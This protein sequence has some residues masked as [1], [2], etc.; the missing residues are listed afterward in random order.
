MSV[1]T[2]AAPAG[3]RDDVPV[4]RLY[5]LGDDQ[6]RRM[7]DAGILDDRSGE[8]SPRLSVA[9]YHEA[10]RLGILTPDDR[11]ELLEGWLVAKM[12]KKP[13]HTIAKGL[14]LDELIRVTPAGWYVVIEDPVSTAESEPEP[15]AMIVRGRRRD[16]RDRQPGP[17]DVAL[18]VEVADSTLADDRRTK[19]RIY[20]RA[21]VAIYWIVNLVDGRVEVYTEPT[22]PDDAPGYARREVFGPDAEIPVLLDGRE[23][24]RVAVRDVLP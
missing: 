3:A 9:Q 22:G 2:H 21:G 17:G 7:V 5:R 19:R 13:P 24:G 1:G 18:V 20:G 11:V 14:V 12:T 16:Y 6:F 23:V 8:R 15:D 10:A 4:D